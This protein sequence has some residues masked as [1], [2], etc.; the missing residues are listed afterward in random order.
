MTALDRI[1][2]V[3]RSNMAMPRLLAVAIS[4]DDP[5]HVLSLATTIARRTSHR[6]LRIDL[7]GAKE[8]DRT[9]K[10]KNSGGPGGGELNAILRRVASNK[11]TIAVLDSMMPFLTGNRPST[12]AAQQR[13]S[14]MLLPGEL[15]VAL[16]TLVFLDPPGSSTDLPLFLSD[17]FIHLTV[18]HPSVDELRGL[19]L[20][21]L[22]RINARRKAGLSPHQLARAAGAL[23]PSLVGSSRSGA[24][25]ALRL[26]LARDL[27]Q[28]N[29]ARRAL[30]RRK[31][32]R[33]SSE[34][35]LRV[36]TDVP[37]ERYFG[38]PYLVEHLERVM[39]KALASGPDR[40][41]GIGLVGP[42]GTA[43]STIAAQI[44]RRL[45]VPLVRFDASAVLGGI[46]GQTEARMAKV[47]LTV[48]SLA[49]VV[50]FIDE[51][52]RTFAASGPGRQG[53]GGVWRRAT[54]QLLTF[55]AECE[56]PVFTVFTANNLSHLGEL[57]IALTRPGR[58]SSCFY[59]GFPGDE[60]RGQM[61]DHWLGGGLALTPRDREE[62]VQRT[63]RFSGAD[64]R[65]SVAQAKSRAQSE[66]RDL[67]LDDLEQAV[68]RRCARAIAIYDECEAMRAHGMSV[69]EPAGPG[70]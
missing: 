63:D 12:A 35:G 44:A 22:T 36:T 14:A 61:L 67:S 39:R 2:H 23:A 28:V 33:L 53:D 52:D 13:L 1:E 59:L 16:L 11:R 30:E 38:Y 68:D 32:A 5:A 66:H 37:L 62:L 18:E 8:L 19:A 24:R 20:A 69:C 55:L 42:P 43:K 60:A 49:P 17:R 57:G 3:V 47:L 40:E 65:T 29:E 41:K 54:G 9:G 46:V 7:N 10:W 27:N 70:I 26:V 25:D 64:I 15:D 4:T 45:G 21:E 50:F 31:A 56:A 6:L 34:L 58:I 48:R 51:L